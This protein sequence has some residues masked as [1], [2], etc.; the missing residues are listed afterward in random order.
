MLQL[1]TVVKE[2]NDLVFDRET[3]YRGTLTKSQKKDLVK[4]KKRIEYLKVIRHYLET[5]PSSDFLN[6]EIDRVENR[7]NLILSHFS[8]SEQ[9][10]QFVVKE[11]KKEYE[12]EHE[13]PKL[14]KQVRALR[15]ILKN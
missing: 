11:L 6:K 7:I 12:K 8:H 14:R 1:S 15:H 9:A 5:K 3:N 4:M 2:M 10:D 13:I